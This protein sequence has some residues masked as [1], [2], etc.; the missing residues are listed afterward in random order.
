MSRLDDDLSKETCWPRR[1]RLPTALAVAI[2]GSSAT[3][4]LSFA[5]CTG[6]HHAPGDSRAPDTAVIDSISIF[7]DDAMADVAID[8]KPDARP[9]ARPDAPPD[10]RP[11]APPDARPDSPPD[12]RPDTPIV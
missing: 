2:I 1:L 4:A 8:A 12:A 5:G 10:A 3:A 6:G 9:D 7:S 11:D